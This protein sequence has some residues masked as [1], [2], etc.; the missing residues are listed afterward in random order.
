MTE[1]LLFSS[2]ACDEMKGIKGWTKSC[3]QSKSSG[4]WLEGLRGAAVWPL[5]LHWL[6]S[7]R[8]SK[9]SDN[10]TDFMSSK[11]LRPPGRLPPFLA[12]MAITLV[13]LMLW[14]L[15]LVVLMM[16]LKVAQGAESSALSHVHSQGDFSCANLQSLTQKWVMNDSYFISGCVYI[17]CLFPE[18]LLIFVIYHFWLID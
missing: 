2:P 16:M 13:S 6:P 8:Q 14:T 10:K 12:K 4:N 17:L 1:S 5:S 3:S 15:V 9:D 11:K 7:I 18:D